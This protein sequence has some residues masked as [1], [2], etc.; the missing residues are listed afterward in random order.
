LRKEKKKRKK[1]KRKEKKRKPQFI[2]ALFQELFQLSLRKK[3]SDLSYIFEWK[4]LHFNDSLKLIG[5]KDGKEKK[6]EEEEEEEEEEEGKKE[7]KEKVTYQ[8]KG[9]PSSSSSYE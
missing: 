8:L 7:G 2:D 5:R 6:K 9:N 1:K 3:K 4:V